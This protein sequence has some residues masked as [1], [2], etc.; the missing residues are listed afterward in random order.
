MSRSAVRVRPWALFLVP[1]RKKPRTAR[2][3]RATGAPEVDAGSGGAWIEEPAYPVAYRSNQLRVTSTPSKRLR[4]T[5]EL[6]RG[7]QQLRT[8]DPT[9]GRRKRRGDAH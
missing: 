6:L 9:G 2:E 7:G 1:I 3:S 5:C 4:K 8:G